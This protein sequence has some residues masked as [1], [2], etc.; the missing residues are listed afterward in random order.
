MTP[1]HKNDDRATTYIHKQTFTHSVSGEPI[2]GP[3]VLQ[4]YDS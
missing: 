1:L 2:P 3:A 4:A